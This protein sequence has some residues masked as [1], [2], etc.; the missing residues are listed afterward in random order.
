MSEYALQVKK[1][2]ENRNRRNN[3]P[4]Y[5]AI[6]GNWLD[7]FPK[8]QREMSMHRDQG[9]PGDIDSEKLLRYFREL[10]KVPFDPLWLYH[11]DR[12]SRFVRGKGLSDDRAEDL[13]QEVAL[14]SYR[15]LSR[16]MADIFSPATFK[17]AKDEIAD[18]YRR[19]QRRPS[20]ETLDDLDG[21]NIEPTAA[22]ANKS[23]ELWRTLK[24]RMDACGVSADQQTAVILHHLVGYTVKEVA[25]ITDCKR[26]TVKSRLRYAAAQMGR[27]QRPED[28]A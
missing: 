25:L 3:A 11:R 23:A 17:I 10:F 12:L 2:P 9:P 24:K 5:P 27:A 4:S 19:Q 7:P 28:V 14:K 15:Y 6:A 16:H 8:G 22:P 21:L 26:E 20:L 13:L 18:H 1:N